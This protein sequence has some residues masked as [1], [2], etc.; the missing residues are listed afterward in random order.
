ML[1]FEK[2]LPFRDM[3]CMTGVE[4]GMDDSKECAREP[5]VDLNWKVLSEG[6]VVYQGSSSGFG[7]AEFTAEYIFKFLGDFS[8]QPGKKYIVELK[9]TK[10]GAPLDIANPHLIVIQVGK[11]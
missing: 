6:Q 8:T 10:D 5:L 3:Q 2:P 4:D 7:G 1:Q 11:E 9:F